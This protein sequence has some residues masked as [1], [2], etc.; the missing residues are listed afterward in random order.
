MLHRF[1]W[2]YQKF[3]GLEDAETAAR[4]SLEIRARLAGRDATARDLQRELA[5][6]HDLIGDIL[7]KRKPAD[8][9]D[10]L[11][12]YRQAYAIHSRLAESSSGSPER[13]EW[14]HAISQSHIRMGDAFFNR[15]QDGDRARARDEYRSALRV[16]AAL[17]LGDL[18][19]DRWKREL[20]WAF[21]KVGSVEDG[22]GAISARQ[23]ALC[24]RRVTSGRSDDIE[25]RR[26]LGFSLMD[27]GGDGMRSRDWEG[28]KTTYFE[29]LELRRALIERDRDRSD[30]ESDLS[31]TVHQLGVLYREEGKRQDVAL[32]FFQAASD[33]RNR[34]L[35]R[36]PADL[37]YGEDAQRSELEL[38]RVRVLVE[39]TGPATVMTSE[40]MNELI[41]GEARTYQAM[42]RYRQ[43]AS[44]GCESN[45]L[46]SLPAVIDGLVTA[47]VQ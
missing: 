11:E 32:A 12:H 26:D 39:A 18:T 29:A 47:N 15:K 37:R 2:A 21:R 14:I 17:V 9:V 13:K 44:A 8:P 28:A 43:N 22:P 6:T 24:L 16:I 20:S 10:A 42:V 23:S 5:E 25:W 4:E 38:T 31:A 40:R 36:F 33:R 46:A 27:V 30:L 35:I 3:G 7:R 19:D 1:A 45:L 41:E 34:L